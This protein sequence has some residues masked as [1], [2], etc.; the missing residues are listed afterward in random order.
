VL[1]ALIMLGAL[2]GVGFYTWLHWDEVASIRLASPLALGICIAALL[3]NVLTVG[4]LF[5][6]T[7]NKLSRCLG[8]GESTGLAILTTA[9]NTL[10]PF[11]GGAWV[12]AVYLKQ[13]HGFD[14]SSFLATLFGYQ[15]LRIL[16]CAV[17]AAAAV[18]WM[19][20]GEHREGQSLLLAGVLLCLGLSGAA[21]CLPRVP[22]RGRWLI[23]H[24]A[25]FTQGWHTLRAEPRFL[26]TLVALVALQL[27]AEVLSFWAAC[28]T[29][30]VRLSIAEAVAVGTL[31]TLVTVLGLT[32]SGLGLYEAMA[33]FVSSLVA[34]N[35]VHSVMAALVSRFVLVGV[36]A[37]LTP[38]AIYALSSGWKRRLARTGPC[39]LARA[40]ESIL[41][42]ASSKEE[43]LRRDGNVNLFLDDNPDPVGAG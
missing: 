31:S 15:V 17:A 16:V 25:S 12:R 19:V 26:A 23:D 33:A 30:G 32:P 43:F 34:L 38:P 4:P 36:L 1:S 13:R 28:A 3:V 39:P 22:A 35:P 18:S 27:A 40:D 20:V 6:L 21:C 11:Q 24:M 7:V 42:Y 14:Y 41:T 8:L 37:V 9:V 10:V 5:Y 2:A 29:I